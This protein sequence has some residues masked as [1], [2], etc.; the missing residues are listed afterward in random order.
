M[1]VYFIQVPCVE[2]SHMAMMIIY[3]TWLLLDELAVAKLDLDEL[4]YA[5]ML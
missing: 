4:F 3:V 5:G 1:R 2:H